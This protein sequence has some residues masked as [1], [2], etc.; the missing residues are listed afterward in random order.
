MAREPTVASTAPIGMG[1]WVVN[2]GTTPTSVFQAKPTRI[3]SFR[4][5]LPVCHALVG[6]NRRLIPGSGFKFL[7]LTLKGLNAHPI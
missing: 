6:E 4:T 1:P 2:A 5:S 3:P 7:N